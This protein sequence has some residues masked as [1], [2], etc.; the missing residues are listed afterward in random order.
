MNIAKLEGGHSGGSTDLA[1][2]SWSVPTT[3]VSIATN[4][5]GA[6]LH[7]WQ[8]TACAGSSIG[9]KGMV[10]AAKTLTLMAIDLYEVPTQ[11][12]AVRKD[13]DKRRAGHV[14][15]SRLPEDAKPPFT[16]RDK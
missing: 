15:H 5:P 4:V 16:Y 7:S 8:S 12:E 11:L 9:R 1:D 10:L 6:P 3:E 14:Y 13:F 2:V